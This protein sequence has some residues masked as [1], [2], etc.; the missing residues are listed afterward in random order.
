MKSLPNRP[1]LD[2]FDKALESLSYI[3]KGKTVNGRYEEDMEEA[4]MS[5]TGL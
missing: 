2:P 1:N 3:P 4:T 5:K